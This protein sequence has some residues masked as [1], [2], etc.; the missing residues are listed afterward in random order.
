M[1][2]YNWR[3]ERKKYQSS[4]QEQ[5]APQPQPQPPQQQPAP[6]P[7]PVQST[8]TSNNMRLVAIIAVVVA[9]VIV[10]VMMLSRPD[11]TVSGP[12]VSGADISIPEPPPT[13]SASP[14]VVLGDSAVKLQQQADKHRHAVGLVVI[15]L[16]LKDGRKFMEA[17]GTAWAFSENKFA[18]N[19]H[20]AFA[21]KSGIQ[22]FRSQMTIL[23]LSEILGVQV[24]QI[25]AALAKIGPEKA[26]SA[27]AQA[28]EK[29]RRNISSEDARILINGSASE[30]YYITHVQTHR[31]YMRVGTKR[32]PDV[33]VLTIEGR[34]SNYFKIASTDKLYKLRSGIPVAFV[35][36]PTE[37]L[38]D[39]NVNLDD[40]VATMQTGVITSVTDFDQKDNGERKN[41]LIRHNLPCTGGASGSPIFDADGEVVA[42]LY[43]GNVNAGVKTQR[44]PSA[45]LVNFGVRADM[46]K[47]IGPKQTLREFLR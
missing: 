5:S 31:D 9:V 40:P 8:G 11:K 12:V 7:A 34:H 19:A 42:L 39:G 2:E 41:Q 46:L 43:A 26:K 10:A 45:A 17:T 44:V 38:A 30:N 22:K 18:T 29:A 1:K 47:G 23:C 37:N 24:N 16:E 3:E 32:D 27:I 21:I 25:E 20:V 35:G 13:P 15:N 33:A 4:K 28:A 36:Y 6:Q 14:A